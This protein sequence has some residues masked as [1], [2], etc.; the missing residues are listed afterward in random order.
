MKKYRK[1]LI[2]MR[3]LFL[4]TIAYVISIYVIFS[5]DPLMFVFSMLYLSITLFFIYVEFNQRLSFRIHKL[6]NSHKMKFDTAFS[7]DSSD[8]CN[9]CGSEYVDFN[10]WHLIEPLN[11]I[12]HSFH[13]CMT[14][15]ESGMWEE[16]INEKLGIAEDPSK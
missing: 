10:E 11:K 1:Q 7:S 16:F 5:A 4:V 2:N 8:I 6:L 9:I 12:V 15:D 14:C 3:I 13:V